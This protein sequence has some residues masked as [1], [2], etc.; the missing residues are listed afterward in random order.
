MIKLKKIN[1]YHLNY[2][3]KNYVIASFGLMKSRPALILEFTDT[4][5]NIGLG[6]IW[7]NFPSDGASYKFNLFKNIFAN[8]LVNSNIKHPKD[9]QSIFDPIK[10]IFVQSNDLG[11][12]NS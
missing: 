3:L 8:K 12:Y 4:N 11:S 7:C 5:N 1:L 10:T 6:E 9:L 2:P